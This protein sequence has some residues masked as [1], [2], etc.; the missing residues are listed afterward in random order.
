MKEDAILKERCQK[1][2]LG[3]RQLDTTT[4][5]RRTEDAI[6]VLFQHT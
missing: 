2:D 6:D 5:L 3:E 4:A 1:V